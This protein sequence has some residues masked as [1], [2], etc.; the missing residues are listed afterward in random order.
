VAIP[1]KPGVFREIFTAVAAEADARSQKAVTAMALA[2]EAQAKV[3]V[4]HGSHTA[5]TPTPAIEGTGPAVISG[6]L[7]RCITH[8]PTESMGGVWRA[9]V[10]P[11]PGFHPP[12]QR[13]KHHIKP[14]PKPPADSARY[15]YYLET[16]DWGHIYPWLGPALHLTEITAGPVILREIFGAPWPVPG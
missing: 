3:N 14:H 16:G 9:M 10:G 4:S 13:V 12:Y 15:G 2:T 7:R 1:L 8:T 11:A 6:T 5:G